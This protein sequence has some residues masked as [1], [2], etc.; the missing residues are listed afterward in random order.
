MKSGAPFL[1]PT[2]EMNA[3]QTE[4]L[5]LLDSRMRLL[6]PQKVGSHYAALHVPLIPGRS[7]RL[8]RIDK[9]LLEAMGLKTSELTT[10]DLDYF[11]ASTEEEFDHARFRGLLR[12][13]VVV[14][15]VLKERK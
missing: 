4:H 15:C 1:P 2:S 13:P 10:Y 14:L 11:G 7:V 5:Q 8:P 9:S 3:L 6:H 12:F